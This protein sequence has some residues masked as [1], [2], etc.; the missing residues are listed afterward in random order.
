MKERI[1][2][3]RKDQKMTQEEFAAKLGVKRNTIATYE[4]GRSDP[5]SAVTSL[6]CKIFNVNRK[7]LEDGIGEMYDP[8]EDEDAIIAEEILS[9]V[10]NELY[11][12]IKNIVKTYMQLDDSGKETIKSFAKDL[13]TKIKSGD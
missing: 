4:M 9:E 5:S 7:W 2:Q 11:S 6:I 3:V 12:I 10:D 13:I 8:I 1:K